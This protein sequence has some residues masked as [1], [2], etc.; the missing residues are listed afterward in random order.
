MNQQETFPHSSVDTEA[1]AAPLKIAV[2]V[3]TYRRLDGIA[4]LLDV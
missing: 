1:G 3:L 2:G 4:K